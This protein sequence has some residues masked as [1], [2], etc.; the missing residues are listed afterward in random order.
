MCVCVCVCVS[1]VTKYSQ[2]LPATHSHSQNSVPQYIYAS[3][4]LHRGG[5][6]Y[7]IH[8]GTE[9]FVFYIEGG[10][11]ILHTA[12]PSS[13]YFTVY[14]QYIYSVTS[15]YRG[16]ETYTIRLQLA[17]IT[18]RK[19]L[20][21][22]KIHFSEKTRAGHKVQTS[23][24]RQFSTIWFCGNYSVTYL[25][26]AGGYCGTEYFELQYIRSNFAL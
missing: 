8:R 25:P 22:W 11:A 15:Q 17:S 23:I 4:S 19:L 20:F 14:T 16:G 7:E 12:V 6:S 13:L 2:C 26:V 21:T 24:W 3:T 1:S 10:K 18:R 9:F 5:E